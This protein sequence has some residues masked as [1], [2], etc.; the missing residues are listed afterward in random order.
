MIS[1]HITT[2]CS[3][4]LGH[5]EQCAACSRETPI[6]SY[7]SFAE[8]S[9]KMSQKMHS[10][11]L[12]R[13]HTIQIL[14]EHMTPTPPYPHHVRCALRHISR[15]HNTKPNSIYGPNIW[16]YK[17][18]SSSLPLSLSSESLLSVSSLPLC[19][20]SDSSSK[21]LLLLLLLALALFELHELFALLEAVES[22]SDSDS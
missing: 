22:A 19:E 12:K 10:H 4:T 6:L 15:T 9:Q 20:A 18:H 1:K 17:N 5:K 2:Y 11:A 13:K 14:G 21:S 16:V 8:K 3:S 7:F